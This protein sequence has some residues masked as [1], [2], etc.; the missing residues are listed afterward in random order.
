MIVMDKERLVML[1]NFAAGV[2]VGYAS[3]LLNSNTYA[4]AS[5][6]VGGVIMN[7]ASGKVAGGKD[8]KWWLTNGGM[9]YAFI[10]F[11]SWVLFL[12]L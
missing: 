11:V 6:L 2:A 8:F 10:W 3:F 7:F 12:N 4:I 1:L 9:V 5:M